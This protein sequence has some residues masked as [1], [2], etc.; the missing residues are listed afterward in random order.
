MAPEVNQIAWTSDVDQALA[1]ALPNPV[2]RD[3]VAAEVRAGV[4]RLWHCRDE[5]HEAYVVTRVDLNPSQLVV[6][7]FEGS[8]M[9][10]FGPWFI[11]RAH[12]AGIPVRAHTVD[13]R[14]ERLLRMG[15]KFKRSEVILLRE[16]DKA[17]A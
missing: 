11:E 7:A 14:V 1:R 10:A 4:S 15:L 9:R 17:A 16:A 6:V 13:P 2:I 5:L 12:A 8:G 3:I